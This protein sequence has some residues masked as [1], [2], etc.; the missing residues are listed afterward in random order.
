MLASSLFAVVVA[1]SAVAAV[2][3]VKRGVMCDVSG[4]TLP[5]PS[6]ANDL[7]TPLASPI[8]GGPKFIGL[9]VGVQNYTCSSAGTFTYGFFTLV[10][11]DPTLIII[12]YTVTSAR[13]PSSSTSP[14]LRAHPLSATSRARLTRCGTPLLR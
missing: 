1:L 7:P 6:T 4:D 11:L 10:A 8:A 13:M 5:F 3:N 12:A 14:A 2:P 9:G